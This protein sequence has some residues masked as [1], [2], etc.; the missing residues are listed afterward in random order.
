MDSHSVTVSEVAK[1]LAH[2]PP[3]DR[4]LWVEMGMAVHAGLGPD[5]CDIWMDW[6]RGSDSFRERDAAATWRSFRPGSVTVGTL[7]FRAA[8]HG[9]KSERPATEL[10]AK[11]PSQ[12][13]IERAYKDRQDAAAA[14][15]IVAEW[16]IDRAK[17]GP[18]PYLTSKGFEWRERRTGGYRGLVLDGDLLVP[19]YRRERRRNTGIIGCQV[20]DDLGRKRFAPDGCAASKACFTLGPV[21]SGGV[22]WWVEGYATGLS[23]WEA[24]KR[25]YRRAD[26][27]NICFSA[28]GLA[29]L[30]RADGRGLIVADND[31]PGLKAARAS[32]L[33]YWI[34]QLEG[35]DANDIHLRLG[36]HE[37]AAGLRHAL[38]RYL[39]K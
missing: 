24:L 27:V 5:G 4:D 34:P 11:P 20:I 30:A 31:A 16:M 9:W 17:Y 21:G 7:F 38:F 35:A 19:M 13:E 28:H 18:H 23:V 1:A 32:G 29:T 15:S 26:R 37:L 33:P 14:A 8:Q 12:V 36:C 22:D 25:L 6:S 2:V 3:D 10:A 39:E